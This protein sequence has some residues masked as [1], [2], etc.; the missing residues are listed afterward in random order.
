MMSTSILLIG[1]SRKD[2]HHSYDIE[3]L[4]IEKLT[5]QFIGVLCFRSYG[6][7]SN[8]KVLLPSQILNGWV[9]FTEEAT[10]PGFSVEETRTTT[11]WMFAPSR[12]TREESWLHLNC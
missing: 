5:E 11:S 9:I 8:V 4:I 1:K 3:K 6:V 7:I 12:V 10:N 2:R